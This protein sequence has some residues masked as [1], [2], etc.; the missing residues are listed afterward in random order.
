MLLLVDQPNCQT[1]MSW[2]LSH[3]I[4]HTFLVFILIL[5]HL[6]YDR[7]HSLYCTRLKVCRFVRIWSLFTMFGS[8]HYMFLFY[9]CWWEVIRFEK[10]K[11]HNEIHTSYKASVIMYYETIGSI[12]M[13]VDQRSPGVFN[14]PAV[15]H[16]WHNNIY[17][18]F[19]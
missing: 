2:I 8:K 16:V 18:S 12:L 11:Q 3:I 13:L 6:N 14:S 17:I 4:L 19:A 9:C 15:R 7:F 10:H 5:N 1:Y